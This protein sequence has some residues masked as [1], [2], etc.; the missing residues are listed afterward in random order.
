M[1]R[2]ILVW[3]LVFLLTV[4]GLYQ[5]KYRVRDVKSDVA[6]LEA[7]LAKEKESLHVLKA[8]WAYL[9][10]PERLQQLSDRHLGLAPL[11]ASQIANGDTLDALRADDAAASLLVPASGGNHE[12]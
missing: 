6:A 5:V 4:L 7:E 11:S 8:E 10:R 9:N 2:S 12:P 3:S 1:N